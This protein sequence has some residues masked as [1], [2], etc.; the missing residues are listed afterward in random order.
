MDGVCVV[1]KP[2]PVP[3]LE[4]AWY[5]LKRHVIGMYHVMYVVLLCH[6]PRVRAV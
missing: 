1:N 6:P 2:S 5:N 4:V 3:I